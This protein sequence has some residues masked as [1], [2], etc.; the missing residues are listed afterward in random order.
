MPYR[1][2]TVASGLTVIALALV[3][4]WAH[5]DMTAG[6]LLPVHW[7]ASG[8]PDRYAE[9]GRVLLKPVGLAAVVSLM[10]AAIP[11]IEPLQHRMDKS[12]T[13]FST[14]WIALLA[15]AVLAEFM[16]VAP[17]LGLAVPHTLPLIG[18]G[19]VMVALGNVLPKSRPGFFVG[20]RTPWTLSDPD[21]WIATHRLGAW[22]MML[23]GVA[24]VIA[25]L[26]PGITAVRGQIVFTAM[27]AAVLPP[28]VYSFVYWR[29]HAVRD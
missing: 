3:A 24:I 4:A 18:I 6:T 22:T 9:A 15:I 19:L 8:E 20:I 10:M 17:V 13:L 12:A 29:R 27:L 1:K 5:A 2:L 25:G 28:I 21:N 26:T 14:A 7:T 16:A 23:A 11:W